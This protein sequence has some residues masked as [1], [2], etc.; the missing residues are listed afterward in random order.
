MGTKFSVVAS[1]SVVVYEEIKVLPLL[2]Q[3]YPQDFVVFFIRDYFR[4]LDNA[5]QKWLENFDIETF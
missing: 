5:F 4:F 2:Q 1:N 3:L